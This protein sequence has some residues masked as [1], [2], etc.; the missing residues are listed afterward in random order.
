[1]SL[2]NEIAT[3]AQE[4]CNQISGTVDLTGQVWFDMNSEA[5]W[6]QISD[7]ETRTTNWVSLDFPE[8][9]APGETIVVAADEDDMRHFDENRQPPATYR[10]VANEIDNE[11]NEEVLYSG[12]TRAEATTTAISC[13]E[14]G[15]PDSYNYFIRKDPRP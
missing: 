6:F 2:F 10:V 12:L 14:M 9:A 1:M 13:R 4:A 3:V 5:V 8:Y 15:E 11:L 7:S